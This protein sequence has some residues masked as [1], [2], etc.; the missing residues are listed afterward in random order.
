[1]RNVYWHYNLGLSV[2]S[3]YH[4]K[5]P[6]YDQENYSLYFSSNGHLGYGFYDIYKWKKPKV[7][8][9]LNTKNI[10][11]NLGSNINTGEDDI[12]FYKINDKYYKVSVQNLSFKLYEV[13]LN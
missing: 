9:D 6:F 5:Y 11:Q 13:D 12:N 8:E 10:I 4:E 7:G 2:N 3:D 1:M